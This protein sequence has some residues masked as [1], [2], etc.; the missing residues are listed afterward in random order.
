MHD[1]RLIRETPD[2]FDRGLARRGLPAASAEIIALDARRRAAQTALQD[3]QA[4]R[5]EASKQIGQVKREGGDAAALMAEV[6]GIK[7]RMAGLEEEERGAAESLELI[8]AR[9]P[10]LPADDTPDGP[11]ET[12]N[13]ELRRHGAPP[14]RNAAPDHVAIGEALGLMDTATAAK[15]SGAR[16]TVLR[17][18]LARLERALGQFMID[19]QTAEFGYTELS[20]PLL[21]KDEAVYGTN[22]LPKFAEDLFRTTGGL[23]LIPTAEVPLTNT[24]ADSILDADELPLRLTALTPCFRSEGGG[25]RARTRAA[26]CASISSG[27][28]SW[29]ASPRPT[30]RMPSMSG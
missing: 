30:N 28:W 26:W 7:V 8:L 18:G 17:A 22:Q 1:L 29:S 15:L 16:F 13:V 20:V 10:N 11:D 3:L 6:E 27:R 24:V 14:R 21:V 23:W 2:L 5:N 19:T 9:L 12:A 25:R 4:R